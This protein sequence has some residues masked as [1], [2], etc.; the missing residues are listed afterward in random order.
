MLQSCPFQRKRQPALDLAQLTWRREGPAV[1]G[2]TCGQHGRWSQVTSLPETAHSIPATASVGP[3]SRQ[4]RFRRP[5]PA[6]VQ[7]GASGPWQPEAV[8]DLVLRTALTL[9]PSCQVDSQNVQ[10]FYRCQRLNANAVRRQVSSCPF[11]SQDKGVRLLGHWK[12]FTSTGCVC[13]CF[14][15]L[16]LVFFLAAPRLS[17]HVWYLIS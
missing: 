10:R 12:Y 15:I 8:I 1:L 9:Q 3:G 16:V 2:K 11:E 17:C 7:S 14:P 6:T 5:L 4:Q 13:V